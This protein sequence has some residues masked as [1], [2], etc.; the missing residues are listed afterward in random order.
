MVFECSQGQPVCMCGMH[1]SSANLMPKLISCYLICFNVLLSEPSP[2]MDPWLLPEPV[3]WPRVVARCQGSEHTIS[4]KC[5]H[6]D[7]RMEKVGAQ[8]GL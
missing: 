3:P 1:D 8:A 4:N 6:G 5:L 2:N 7:L